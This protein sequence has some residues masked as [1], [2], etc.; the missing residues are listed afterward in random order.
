MYTQA[1][2]YELGREYARKALKLAV[3]LGNHYIE[4]KMIETLYILNYYEGRLNESI[5]KVLPK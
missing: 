3:V 2:N 1:N 5:E 4:T